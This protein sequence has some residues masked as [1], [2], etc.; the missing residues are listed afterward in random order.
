MPFWSDVN[1][2]SVD[3]LAVNPGVTI[4]SQNHLSALISTLGYG[5]TRHD[6]L[7]HSSL[8]WKGWYPAVEMDMT[9]GGSPR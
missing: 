2:I 7:L 6:H 4:M 3:N 1:N 8:L 5:Y 9:W